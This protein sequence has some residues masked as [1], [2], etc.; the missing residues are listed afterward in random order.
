M[1]NFQKNK[2]PACDRKDSFAPKRG[3][4]PIKVPDGHKY[5]QN[6]GTF[7]K[8]VNKNEEPM[9]TNPNSVMYLP[10]FKIP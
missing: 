7:A 9:I 10:Y 4:A 5:L 6:A 8:P 1:P 2:P 3:I